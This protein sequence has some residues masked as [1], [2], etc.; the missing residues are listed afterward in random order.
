[1]KRGKNRG[2]SGAIK[3]AEDLRRRGE[4]RTL[5]EK[6]KQSDNR[7]RL[8]DSLDPETAA[9]ARREFARLGLF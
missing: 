6:I 9:F 1:M 7:R 4:K 2:K 5:D 3:S 8:I